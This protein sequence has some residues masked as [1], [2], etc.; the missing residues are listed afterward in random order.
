VLSIVLV[1]PLFTLL[2]VGLS[3]IIS[4][5]VKDPNTAQQVG[6]VVLLPLL[7][8]MIVQLFGVTGSRPGLI[9]FTAVLMVVVDVL[10][11]RIAV[12]LFKREEI[13]TAWR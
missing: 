11:M 12:R 5:K 7:G 4:S 2:T 8:V 3:I 6:T 1:T 9:L 10:V 13:L